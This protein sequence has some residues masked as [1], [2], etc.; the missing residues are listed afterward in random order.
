M[1]EQ[2]STPAPFDPALYLAQRQ[3]QVTA[4]H[5]PHI[6]PLPP[7]RSVVHV[8]W[9]NV[10]R[11]APGLAT[12]SLSALAWMW[13][14][15]IP[16]GSTEPLWVMGVL[17]GFTGAIGVVAA[18]KQ[19]GDSETV[20][21]AFGG[22]VMLVVTGVSAWTPDLP[23]LLLL[24]VLATAAAYALCA[25]LWR[26][27]RQA[28]REQRHELT[29]EQTRGFNRWRLLATQASAQVAVAQLE[30][31][32][33]R[34]EVDKILAASEAR[35]ARTLAPGEETDVKAL[36]RAVTAPAE[37]DDPWVDSPVS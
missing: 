14:A 12:T 25:P 37:G 28:L 9:D 29:M 2:Q 1:N 6:E 19:H 27:D 20:R 33:E 30:V 16:D 32:R 23:L 3:H 7:V 21:T 35:R 8:L 17:A 36:L 26:T 13:N 4:P 31:D 18:A 5:V 24:W 11:V 34:V 10:G 15:Q 22:S